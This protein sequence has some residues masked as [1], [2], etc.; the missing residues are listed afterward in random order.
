[1]QVECV[2][3][4]CVTGTLC[5]NQQLQNGSYAL[6]A[7]KKLHDKGMSL[8]AS[9]LILPG[10]FVC[11]YT[12]EIIHRSTYWRREKVRTTNYYGMSLTNYEVLDARTCGSVARFANHSCNPNCVVERWEV[13]GE[14]CCGFFAKRLIEIDEEITIGYGGGNAATKVRKCSM[15]TFA[16]YD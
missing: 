3:G 11:Q 13:N 14:I 9:Q 6:L 12:G 1:M 5:S 10:T 16:L 2:S 15:L 4:K 7:V 8:F